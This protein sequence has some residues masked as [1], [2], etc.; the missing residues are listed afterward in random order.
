MAR[1]LD[2]HQRLG[3]LALRLVG[4]QLL[5]CWWALRGGVVLGV[6]PATAGLHGV[7]RDLERRVDDA[8]PGWR[9]LRTA[10]AAHARRERSSANRLGALLVGVWAVVLVAR[11]V[12]EHV[13]LGA[14]GPLLAG[15]H[16]VLGVALGL[17]TVLA[18]PL[19]AHFDGGALAV[20]RHA[21]VLALG[22]PGTALVAGAGA[23]IVLC[24]YYLLPGLTVVLGVVAPAAVVTAVLWRTGVLVAP[25]TTSAAAFAGAGV[26]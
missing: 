8:E 17:V 24:G 6:F 18:W 14:T 3:R 11:G 21:V 5:W 9:E 2:L 13:D 25:R 26:G 15:G 4:L 12:V 20:L 10:F 1:L 19:Q 16:T 23:G 22:R 7:L